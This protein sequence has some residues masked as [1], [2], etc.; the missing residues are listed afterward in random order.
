ML[1][2]MWW[3]VSRNTKRGT[4]FTLQEKRQAHHHSPV[5][6]PGSDSIIESVQRDVVLHERLHLHHVGDVQGVV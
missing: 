1:G 5:E 3:G 4:P 2:V 6:D